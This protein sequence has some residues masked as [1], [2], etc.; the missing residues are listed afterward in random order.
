MKQDRR[1]FLK[2]SLSIGTVTGTVLATSAL[3]N[4]KISNQADGNGVV[5]GKSKKKEILYSKS[6]IWEQYYKVAY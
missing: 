2:K 3:A 5:V 4:S 6:A 1:E